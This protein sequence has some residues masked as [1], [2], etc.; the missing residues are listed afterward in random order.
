M[1][2]KVKMEVKMWGEK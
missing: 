1:E 2:E